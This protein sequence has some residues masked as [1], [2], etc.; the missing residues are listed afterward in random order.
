MGFNSA[1]KG[2]IISLIQTSKDDYHNILP[3]ARVHTY[4]IYTNVSQ[5]FFHNSPSEKQGT[6]L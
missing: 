1:F 2:L 5:E 4:C 6:I 3:H